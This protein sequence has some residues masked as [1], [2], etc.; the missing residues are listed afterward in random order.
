M[1]SGDEALSSLHSNVERVSISL[2]EN[3]LAR[4]SCLQ[5]RS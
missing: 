5:T 3:L 4:G 1:V 2:L